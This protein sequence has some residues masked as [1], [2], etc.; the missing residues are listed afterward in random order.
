[1][2]IASNVLYIKINDE[3]EIASN[4]ITDHLTFLGLT[5]SPS[6]INNYRDDTLQDGQI[7][8][9]SRYNQTTVTAKF[10]LQWIDRKDYK[11][12]K[13]EV[14]RVFAQKG[15][16]RLRTATEP[17]IVRYCRAGSFSIDSDPSDPNYCTFEVPFDNPTGLRFSRLHTDKM[18][19]KDFLSLN[20]N[21]TN[22]E[23]A[24]HFV[25]RGSFEVLNAGDITVDPEMQNHDLKITMKH[26]GGKFTLKNMTTNTSW[27]YNKN[28]SSGD[29]VILNGINTYKNDKL[30]SS[31]TDYG[32]LTLKPGI[33]KITVE[34][35]NDLD[36][37]FSFPFMYLG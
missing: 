22:T 20:L 30:D 8:N 23:N 14:F 9:Y 15:I 6:L 3:D 5:E 33:N 29:T 7:W 10:L 2:I 16:F 32:Y 12:A 26:S 31:S 24:Y 17:D 35:A 19:H 4:E 28:L 11:L 34:G 37:T 13:H 25:G 21:L 18:N 36:I 1:M 27:T